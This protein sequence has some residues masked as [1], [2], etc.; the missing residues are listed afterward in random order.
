MIFEITFFKRYIFSIIK[1]NILI[2][3]NILEC[4]L[5]FNYH[6]DNLITTYV[7]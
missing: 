2:E 1:I 6:F 5:E 3:R 7:S 4:H